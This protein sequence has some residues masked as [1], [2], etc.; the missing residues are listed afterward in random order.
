MEIKLQTK[1]LTKVINS[2]ERYKSVQKAEYAF[3]TRN[4]TGDGEGA[5][6]RRVNTRISN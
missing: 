4:G 6:G 3:Y 2:G 1:L 5:R